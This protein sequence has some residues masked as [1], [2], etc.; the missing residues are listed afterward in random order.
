MVS[1]PTLGAL[2]WGFCVST[3]CL[4]VCSQAPC[5]CLHVSPGT[6][7]GT[8]MPLLIHR[9]LPHCQFSQEA[10]SCLHRIISDEQSFLG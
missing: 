9:T 6:T 5:K 8:G 2:L 3:F 10:P 1:C 7:L 4:A